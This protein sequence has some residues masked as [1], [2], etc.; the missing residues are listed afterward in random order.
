MA[1]KDMD[2]SIA[3]FDGEYI[4]GKLQIPSH[5]LIVDIQFL[6]AWV[7]RLCLRSTLGHNRLRLNDSH[8]SILPSP[9]LPPP[10]C[11]L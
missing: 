9:F 11:N 3:H 2:F 7:Y 1:P 4:A 5:T 6:S 10:R 8:N